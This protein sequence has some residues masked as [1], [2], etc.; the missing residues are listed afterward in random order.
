[1]LVSFDVEDELGRPTGK[2]V[3]HWCG[4]VVEKILDGTWLLPIARKKCYKV[5]EAALVLWDAIP[6]IYQR[7][8]GSRCSYRV[9][10]IAIVRGLGEE[11]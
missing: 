9:N 7:V 6:C 11:I 2:K 3:M 1:M 4:G 5:N 10:G 8:R